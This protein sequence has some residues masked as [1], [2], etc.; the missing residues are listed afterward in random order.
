M[1][2]KEARIYNFRLLNN[3]LS[4]EIMKESI[5]TIDGENYTFVTH[6]N[7]TSICFSGT[8]API[9]ENKVIVVTVPR[10]IVITRNNGDIL[11]ILRGGEKD[12]YSVITAQQLYDK[13]AYQWFEPLADNYR[14]LLYV[15][16]SDDVKEAYRHFTWEDID[17]FA[18]VERPSWEYKNNWEG[19]W[20]SN[21]EGGA[22][23]LMSMINGIPYWN[24]AVGQIPFAVDTYRLWKN[25]P[26]TVET[27]ITWATGRP[28]DAV[29][30]RKDY[31]NK[32]DNFFVLRGA[33]YAAKK[34]IYRISPHHYN[35]PSVNVV[36]NIQPINASLLGQPISQ[37]DF[38]NYA[39]W[40]KKQ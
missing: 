8:T 28:K 13:L 25:I 31:S 2:I 35:Y 40:N 5:I 12:K 16:T 14:E 32:Y 37:Q 3:L 34:F 29:M 30:Q 18:C 20:K 10:V 27:G 9:A 6:E 33:L 38:D 22:G 39:I 24:D 7:R 11:F 19:D 23:Y 1:F 26:V 4:V 17:K 21:P 15:N 36:E